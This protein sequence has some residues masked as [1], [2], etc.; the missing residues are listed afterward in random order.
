MRYKK[1]TYNLEG[2]LQKIQKKLF[3]NHLFCII[4]YKCTYTYNYDKQMKD[5]VDFTIWSLRPYP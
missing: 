4:L 5:L 3:H 2:H 1:T